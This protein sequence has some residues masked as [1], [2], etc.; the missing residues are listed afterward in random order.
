MPPDPAHSAT[1]R[2]RVLIDQGDDDVRAE[3]GK[4]IAELTKRVEKLTQA[5]ED[6]APA[7]A[8]WWPDLT[9]AEAA[10]LWTKLETWVDDVFRARYPDKAEQLPGCWQDHPAMVDAVTAGWTAWIDAYRNP[11]KLTGPITWQADPVHGLPAMLKVLADTPCPGH[12]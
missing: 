9:D 6:T 12:D 2:L 10:P 8:V 11:G 3:V 5:I 7:G 1:A 4:Q